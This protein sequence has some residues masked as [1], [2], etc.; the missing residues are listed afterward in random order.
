MR[1]SVADTV[2]VKFLIRYEVDCESSSNASKFRFQRMTFNSK[3]IQ[4]FKPLYQ[5][6]MSTK[7]SKTH[8]VNLS[9]VGNI[10][11]QIEELPE[12]RGVEIQSPGNDW[13]INKMDD[14]GKFFSLTHKD[15]TPDSDQVNRID[16]SL[17]TIKS[18]PNLMEFFKKDL[19]FHLD[20]GLEKKLKKIQREE[21]KEVHFTLHWVMPKSG[22][23][24][25][26]TNFFHNVFM[27]SG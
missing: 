3:I 14:L 22:K 17:V 9:V 13:S 1:G 27:S 20:N 19:Q 12:V 25:F 23:S 10:G 11:R 2:E 24:G 18:D 6:S 21:D 15:N 16:D 4:M 26:I 8:L 7:H 5:I